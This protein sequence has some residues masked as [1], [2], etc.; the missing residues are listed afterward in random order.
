MKEMLS[1]DL[2]LRLSVHPVRGFEDVRVWPSWDHGTPVPSVSI[3]R[4]ST[5]KSNFIRPAPRCGWIACRE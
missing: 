2:R 1:S 4:P 3:R 5:W